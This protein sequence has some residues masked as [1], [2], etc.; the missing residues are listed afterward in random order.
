MLVGDGI[1]DPYENIEGG[2]VKVPGGMAAIIQ[3]LEVSFI[4]FGSH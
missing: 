2:N 3:K 4:V 1:V